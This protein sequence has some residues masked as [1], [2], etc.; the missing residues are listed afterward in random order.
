MS[1]G[2]AK[3]AAAPTRAVHDD[4]NNVE[5]DICAICLEPLPQ[6][7]LDYVRFTCCGKSLH[8]ECAEQLKNSGAV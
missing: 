1:E 2:E 4:D 8:K 5:G 3:S 7:G 6:L